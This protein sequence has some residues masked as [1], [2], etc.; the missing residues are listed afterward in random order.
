MSKRACLVL[1]M[2]AGLLFGAAPFV[3]AQQPQTNPEVYSQLQFRYHEMSVG[4][5]RGRP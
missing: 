2:K 4:I 1:F 3:R 5:F